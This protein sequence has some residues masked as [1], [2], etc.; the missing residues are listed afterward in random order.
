MVMFKK[1]ALDLNTM[2]QSQDQKQRLSHSYKYC[3]EHKEI[4]FLWQI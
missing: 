4:A 2:C 1:N 3:S